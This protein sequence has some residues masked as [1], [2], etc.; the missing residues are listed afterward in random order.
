VYALWRT[1]ATAPQTG[2]HAAARRRNLQNA[3]AIRP[4]VGEAV[5]DRHIRGRVVLVVDDVRTTGATL[6]A[7]ARALKAAGA[8]EVRTATVAT[9]RAV[10]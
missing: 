2:L 4:F 10:R 9:A 7:C 8:K 1:R 6:E 5:L 3:I